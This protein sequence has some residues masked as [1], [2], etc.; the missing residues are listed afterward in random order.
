MDSRTKSPANT[1]EQMKIDIIRSC[2]A[3]PN[4]AVYK[5]EFPLSVPFN[6]TLLPVTKRVLMRYIEAA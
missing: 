6:E 5:V 4:P 1:Y 3:L 2:R